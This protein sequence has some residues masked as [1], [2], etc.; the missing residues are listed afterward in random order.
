M[1][2]IRVENTHHLSAKTIVI[3]GLAIALVFTA[4]MLLRVQ[5]P[6]AGVGGMIHLGDLPLFVFAIL[7]GRR[8]GALSG[9]IG[10]ALFDLLSGWAPWAPFTLVLAGVMGWFV[11]S[12]AEGNPEL[13]IIPFGVSML[14]ANGITIVGYYIT[15]GILY[16]NWIAPVTS[17]PVNFCQVTLAGVL[18]YPISKRLRPYTRQRGVQ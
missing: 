8:T 3:D 17:I 14:V 10:L 2:G 4:A 7:Y 12:A 9:A 5:I 11:G 13:N 6:I 16:G 1:N 18:A 15:E